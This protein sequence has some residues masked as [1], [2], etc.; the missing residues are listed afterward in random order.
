MKEE[1]HFMG[2][3]LVHFQTVFTICSVAG[4]LPFAFLFPKV[5]MQWLIPGMELAW[6]IFNLLQYRAASYSEELGYRV[7]IGLA[8]VSDPWKCH[9]DF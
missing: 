2:N 1:L 9:K 8:E 4:Q 5:R 6:G 7:L 3:E